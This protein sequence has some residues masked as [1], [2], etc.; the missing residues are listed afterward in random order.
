MIAVVI[1]SPGQELVDQWYAEETKYN[2]RKPEDKT[3]LPSASFPA[4]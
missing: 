4:V 3:G 2:Y 1:L